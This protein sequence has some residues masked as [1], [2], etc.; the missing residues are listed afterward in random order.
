MTIG[1][2]ARTLVGHEERRTL[3]SIILLQNEKGKCALLY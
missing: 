1:D 3:E 2:Q